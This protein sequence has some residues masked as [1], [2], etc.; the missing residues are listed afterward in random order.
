MIVDAHLVVRLALRTLLRR[1]PHLEVVG[2]AATAADALI[3]GA[4]LMPDV[5]VL[6]L[7]LP[8]ASGLNVCRKLQPMQPRVLALTSHAE[9]RTRG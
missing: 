8:D 9:D 7:R 2:E 5:V 6:D 1:F 4:R 3:E